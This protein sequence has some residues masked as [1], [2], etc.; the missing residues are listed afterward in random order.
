MPCPLTLG[1]LLPVF[2]FRLPG[3]AGRIPAPPGAGMAEVARAPGRRKRESSWRGDTS[4][5]RATTR[6][7]EAARRV[8]GSSASADAQQRGRRVLVEALYWSRQDAAV[9][10]EA[11][12]LGGPE[13]P[14]VLLFRAVSSL[15]LEL[16]RRPGPGCPAF[17]QGKGLF[18]ARPRI[19]VHRRGTR[20]PSVVQ[21][22]GPGASCGEERAGAG[23]LVPGDSPSGGRAFVQSIP[24][25]LP[26]ERSWRISAAPTFSRAGSLPG[27][28]SWRRLPGGSRGRL[29]RTPRNRREGCSGAQRNTPAPCRGCGW[30]HVMRLRPSSRT[31]CAG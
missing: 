29:E 17:P 28:V 23:R 16:P 7:I 24:S 6:A 12:R 21:R 25:R 30:R 19:H 14:E 27:R 31:G 5:R 4:R 15:R 18:A 3:Q 13:D 26:M 2:R 9:L 1:P 10:R 22:A 8:A 20:I 11:Q